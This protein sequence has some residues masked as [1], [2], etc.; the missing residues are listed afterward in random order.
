M[1][2]DYRVRQRDYLLEISR[3]LT[4]RLDLTE[5]LKLM[6]QRSTEI[7]DGQAALIALV[8]PGSSGESQYRIRQAYGIAR[9]LLDQLIPMLAKHT[10]IDEAVEALEQHL[11]NIAKQSGLG[12]WQV[13]KLPLNVGGDFLGMMYVFRIAGGAF[14]ANE[15][16]V[17][18]SFAEQAAIAVNNARLYQ[19]VAQEKRRLDAILE[20]SADGV[21]IM[22][23]AHHI[24]TFN[25]SL[26][27]LSGLSATEVL[28]KKFE[29]VMPLLNKRA[30]TTLEE[31]EAMGWPIIGASTPL[32]VEADIQRPDGKKV[33]VEITFAP[34]FDRTDS[35]QTS[36]LVNIIANVRD[37]SRF[38]QADEMKSTFISAV[39]HELKTP[40]ALIKGYASTLRRNDANWDEATLKDSLAVIEEESDR[41]TELVENLLD[42]SRV[43]S[44]NFRLSPVELDIDDLV[45]RVARKFRNQE[46]KHEIVVNVPVDVPLVQADEARITQVLNNLISNAIKYSP[47][48]SEIHIS[49]I[50][51]P[52]EVVITVADQGIGISAEDQAKLFDR[53]FR[54]DVAIKKSIPGTGLGLFLS[55]AIVEAHGGRIWVESQ[56]TTG[57]GL[58]GAGSRFSFS[59]PRSQPLLTDGKLTTDRSTSVEPPLLLPGP[60]PE[61]TPDLT[62]PAIPNA[63]QS[64]APSRNRAPT[65]S[66]K[67][68]GP[69]FVQNAL[70]KCRKPRTSLCLK[71]RSQPYNRAA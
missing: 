70:L 44:G 49:S 66:Q 55:K 22:D 16:R 41:L 4:S 69:A 7:L 14:T 21:I 8:E 40:I 60:T 35:R 23:G 63:Q 28:G 51:T 48:G 30:G 13:V 29:E 54:T 11:I 5:V 43:Q 52:N 18:Q 2:P 57:I 62:G 10:S 1:L 12:S 6:L 19:Q 26:A 3:A 9:P 45:V 47:E 32:F 37:I 33:G 42:A 24:T 15:R 36:R 27:A 50:V 39:S 59:L 71:T 61:S 58:T 38:R 20:Y 68:S 31:A 64:F 34:T 17:L 67:M 25:R 46:M 56:G 65:Q 53:F